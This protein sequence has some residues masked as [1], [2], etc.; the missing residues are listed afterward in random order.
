M[1]QHDFTVGRGETFQPVFQWGSATL[2]SIPITAISQAAP[3]VVTASGHGVPPDWEVA[4]ASAKGMTQINAVGY[5]PRGRDWHRATVLTDNTV[6][7]RDVNSADFSAYTSGGFLVYGTPVDLTSV[8]AV[9]TIRDA[10]TDGAVVLELTSGAGITIDPATK[11]ITA[12]IETSALSW[13]SGYYSLLVAD[14][15]TGKTTQLAEGG[16]SIL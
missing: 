3:A 4:V 14:T 1:S 6:A 7:L 11:T 2:T 12:T 9:M 10:P 16:I 5:P 8:T 15:S 13:A